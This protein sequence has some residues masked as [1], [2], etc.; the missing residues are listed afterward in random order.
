MEPPTLAQQRG[1]A[2]API[3]PSI[4]SFLSC[5]YVIHHLVLSQRHKLQR[6]YHRLI[7]AM[8]ISLAALSCVWIWAPFAVPE[9][10]EYFVAA[11]GSVGT[12]TANGTFF[13]FGDAPIE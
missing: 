9:G 2:Y 1:L 11:G 6:L 3:P 8:N 10:T 5:A 13:V 7:L 4:L 12:C